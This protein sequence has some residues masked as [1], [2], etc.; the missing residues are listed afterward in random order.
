[1]VNSEKIMY[2]Y[3]SHISIVQKKIK[4]NEDCQRRKTII[5]FSKTIWINY[6]SNVWCQVSIILVSTLVKFWFT[7]SSCSKLPPLLFLE[8]GNF[9]WYIWGTFRAAAYTQMHKYTEAIRDCLKSIEI[10]PNYSKAYSRLGLA[11]YAQGNYSDAIEKGFKK[12]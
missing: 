3:P 5:V 10:D 6:S 9:N 1:M 12:G 4:S 8:T 7:L 11:Y 2:V